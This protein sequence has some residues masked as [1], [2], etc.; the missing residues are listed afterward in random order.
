MDVVHERR[1][2]AA[3]LTSMATHAAMLGMAVLALR[4]GADRSHDL[5]TAVAR[6]HVSLFW[7]P[8]PGPD[9]GGGGGG[10]HTPAPPRKAE[11]RG[12]D[13]TTVP[14]ARP[15]K[16]HVSTNTRTDVEPVQRLDIPVVALASGTEML[17]GTIEAPAGPPTAS[18]GSGERGGAGTGIGGGDGPGH[19]PG[20]GLGRGGNEGGGAYQIRGGVTPPTELRRGTP[21]YTAAAMN[22]RAQGI[23]IVECVVQTSGVC[24]NIR[25]RRSLNPAFGLDEEAIRA[26]AQWRFR[27]GMRRGEPVPV[28]VTLEIAFS[29]R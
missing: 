26:A 23:I 6:N 27:P 20:F 17:P 18:Q 8:R 13:R 29:L 4:A 25:V 19:G 15:P 24:A 14:S 7:L 22:A 21:Q 11:A 2:G 10:D 9:G 12:A 5:S 1:Y 28:L 3:F 16:I